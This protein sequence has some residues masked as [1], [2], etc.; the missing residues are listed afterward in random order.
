MKQWCGKHTIFSHSTVSVSLL[1]CP[2]NT[3]SED[4]VD[5]VH[6][7]YKPRPASFYLGTTQELT[8]ECEKILFR[9][10]LVDFLVRAVHNYLWDSRLATGE[11]ESLERCGDEVEKWLKTE[12]I[13]FETLVDDSLIGDVLERSLAVKYV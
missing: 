2:P 1:P 6:G 8:Q 11:A 5:I 13:K 3:P 9:E 7:T 10:D 12:L 4:R